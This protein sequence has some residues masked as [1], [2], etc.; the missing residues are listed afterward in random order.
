M[1]SFAIDVTVR[2][3]L[4][5]SS[6]WLVAALAR[7][8]SASLRA[9]IWTVAFAS[10]LALPAIVRITP[11]WRIPVLPA[12]AVPARQNADAM[13]LADAAQAGAEAIAQPAV[14]GRDAGGRL[15]EPAVSTLSA[16]AAAPHIAQQV[17]REAPSRIERGSPLTLEA[18]ALALWG[19][20][21]F[22]WLARVGLNRAA[23]A[24]VVRRAAVSGGDGDANWRADIDATR[25]QLGIRRRVGIRFTDAVAVPAIIGVWR[26]VLLLPSDAGQWTADAR[27][28]VILHEL[29]HVARWDGLDQLIA[30]VG[31]AL[32]WIVPPVWI[33]ARAAAALR[34]QATDDAVLRAGVKPSAY[35]ANLIDLAGSVAGIDA[36]AASLAMAAS[37]IQDRVAAILDP[38]ARRGRVTLRGA[39]TL[40]ALA[41]VAV[42]TLA[43]VTP[44]RQRVP[45]PPP[46][47]PPAPAA[48]MSPPAP[49]SQV[50]LTAP[51]A[52]MPPLP[53]PASL[54][55]IA[56]SAPMA[57]EAP[58]PPPSAVAPMPPPAFPALPPPAPPPPPGLAVVS[59][60]SS[61]GAA[62]SALCAD[63]RDSFS[64]SSNDNGSRRT[65]S[66]TISGRDCRVE[67]KSEGKVEF[68]D[69]F[70]DVRSITPSGYFRLSVRRADGLHELDIDGQGASLTRTY[71]VDGSTR[72]YDAEAKAW[73]GAIL[74][75]LDRETA[76]GVDVRLPALL[77]QGGVD[78][79]LKETGLM[80]SDYARSRYYAKLAEA[81]TLTSE[82]AGRILKQAASLGTQD[83]YASELLQS[84][85]SRLG[86]SSSDR[87]A[88]F[89]L[90]DGMK[91]DYYIAE[92]VK[93]VFSARRI[94]AGDVDFLL[95]LTPK[96]HSGY[97]VQ[98][99][100]QRLVSSGRLEGAQRGQ[101]AQVLTGMHEDYYMAEIVTAL[102]RDGESDAA[103][104]RAIIGAV[105][106]I[107][108]GYY[109]SEAVRSVLRDPKLD[110]Q[111]LLNLVAV[112]RPL[113]EES[114]KAA[115]LRLILRHAN[116]TD[117]VRQAAID[118]A[119]GL[120]KYYRDD[121]LRPI[122][123]P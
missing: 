57:P 21:A 67:L 79:V 2:A 72:P 40:I 46:L 51:A 69:D 91:S 53:P 6:A 85:G 77:K 106:R 76:V 103:G 18:S 52:P 10:V 42:T 47:P 60:S 74:I 36:N 4:L 26:P 96:I 58:P 25:A 89:A 19:L 66:V 68:T 102:M 37:R 32:Y 108:S 24:Q 27:R 101:L 35:A 16:T 12:A 59:R 54:V 61:G 71:R 48:P 86:D 70:T 33:A 90:I 39:L 73:F 44:E 22:A 83:Y 99:V 114:Y 62:P 95:R 84:V 41:G 105:S 87:A 28:V 121:V 29:A 120:S 82:Q 81:V 7:R 15:D 3:L 118:A 31:C 50:P 107:R 94:G 92:S 38:S 80:P 17:E 104:R 98:E 93:T 49:I 5:M 88:L 123:R 8:A 34:E 23:A 65:W 112:A 63:G 119:A 109:A 100:V 20:V 115:T 30:E 13:R 9:G 11:A 117:K 97:Y 78:A 1:S 116:A 75:E 64:S 110:E 113:H 45:P 56:P 55:P 122:R 111:D 43:A 14:S